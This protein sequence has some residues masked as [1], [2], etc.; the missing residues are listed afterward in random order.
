M[1]FFE[2]TM[3]LCST[4]TPMFYGNLHL[5]SR[6]EPF[7]VNSQELRLRLAHLEKAGVGLSAV[8]WR[9]ASSSMSLLS[10]GVV[11]LLFGLSGLMFY[12]FSRVL[13]QVI[14]PII[15]WMFKLKVHVHRGT[16]VKTPR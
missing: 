6:Q 1:F 15:V 14:K 7:C 10:F 13:Q 12:W 4:S 11:C 8:S 9:V 3:Y 5:G 16:V 2:V